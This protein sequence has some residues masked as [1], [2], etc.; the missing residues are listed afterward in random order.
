MSQRSGNPLRTRGQR[1]QRVGE[2]SAFVL[3]LA[4]VLL[5]ATEIP[6]V[7]I[8]GALGALIGISAA[9]IAAARPDP[10]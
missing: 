4:A 3:A 6:A 2:A 8:L 5:L 7:G 9:W 1:A 10:S